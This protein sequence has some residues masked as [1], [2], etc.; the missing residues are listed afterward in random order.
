[1]FIAAMRLVFYMRKNLRVATLVVVLFLSVLGF[2][3]FDLF[4][5]S[6]LS[7]YNIHWKINIT[8]EINIDFYGAI[9][10]F[11]VSVCCILCIVYLSKFSFKRYFRYFLL[12]IVLALIFFRPSGNAISGPYI[13][14]TLLISFLAVFISFYKARLSEFLKSRD[15]TKLD[16][17]RRNHVAAILVATSYACLSVSIVDLVYTPFTTWTYIGAMG[18]MDG[19]FLSGLL[20]PLAVTFAS[21]F[22]RFIYEMKRGQ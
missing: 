10:P 19:I 11:V 1:M 9:V 16:F 7:V 3:L 4:V 2:R 18:L 14:F 17:S 20:S 6:V 13:L 5:N 15:L 8:P 22:L 21:L 12:A